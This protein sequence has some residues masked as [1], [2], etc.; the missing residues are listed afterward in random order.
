MSKRILEVCA[1]TFQSCLI[2]E[3]AGAAR[4]ELCDN[5][6]EGGTTPSYGVIRQVRDRLSIDLYPIIR[7]RGGNFFYHADEYAIIKE[8]IACCKELHCE[9]ISI[10]VQNARGGIDTEGLKRIVEWAWPLKLTFNRAFDCTPDPF[11]ALEDLIA[12]G[13]ARVLTS[14]QKS[15]AAEGSGLLKKLVQAAGDRIV[16]M[17]GAGIRS[18][19]LLQL[20]ESC[21]AREYHS[22]AR[23]AAGNAPPPINGLA[24][25]FGEV[26]VADEEELRTMVDILKKA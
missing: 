3:R 18:H 24:G 8:D 20:V 11:Q 15:T 23:I 6:A 12:C 1:Y 22:S 14:G 17:P 4:V 25:E 2:A 13:C 7:P 19:N 9:G 21:Q 26:A 16:I 10:G 5:A